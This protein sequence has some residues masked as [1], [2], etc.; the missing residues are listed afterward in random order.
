MVTNPVNDAKAVQES[1]RRDVARHPGDFI[2]F[3]TEAGAARFFVEHRD[4]VERET[5]PRIISRGVV[6]YWQGKT[7]VV[8]PW[9]YLA[10]F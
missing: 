5:D 7:V 9:G 1:L 3:A 6:G 10:N 4:D 8:L 2:V